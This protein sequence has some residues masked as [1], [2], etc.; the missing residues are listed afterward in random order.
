[1]N[2]YL[3]LF[4]VGNCLM[5][6]VALV[7]AV[8]VATGLDLFDFWQEILVG[9][10]VVFCF[11]AGGNALNDYTDREVDKLAH[12]ERPIPSGR[13]TARTALNLSAGAFIISIGASLLLNWQSI[14][15]VLSAIIIIILYEARTKKAGLTGNLSIAWLT[16]ALF[17]LGG[18]M[19]GQLDRTVVIAAMA[20]LATLGR[21]IVKDIEDMASDFDRNTLPK[22]I[23]KRNAGIIGSAAFLT[24]VAFS[25]SPY[26]TG[27]FGIWYMLS[28]LVADAI[29]I[30]S[31]IVHFQNP[32]RGQTWAK[33]GMAAALV[34]FLIGG[35]T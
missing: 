18:A 3:Q 15:I 25:P 5:A 26:L 34:A 8:L 11:V 9:G 27:I 7:L 33:I 4:R 35:I 21:E 22:R 30:Y 28:V 19:V 2:K 31:S 20:G 24:A 32:K 14:L 12:P 23:G 1:M 13:M 29:F 10:V 6:V 16:S 17:L